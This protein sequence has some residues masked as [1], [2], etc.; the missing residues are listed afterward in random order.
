V[1]LLRDHEI[2]RVYHFAPLHYLP[3][4][5]RARALKSKPAL[6]E[7]GY[8][9]T[10]FRSTSAHIDL[11]RGFGNYVHLSTV[12]EPPILSAKLGAGFPH[13]AL[14]LDTECFEDVQFDLCRFNIAKTR[15]LRRDGKPGFCESDVNGKYYGAMQIPIAR[16]EVEKMNLL[17]SRFGN[18]MIEVLVE[19]RLPIPAGVHVKAYS[20]SDKDI[21][22][23]VLDK[24]D[25]DWLVDLAIPPTPYERDQKYGAEVEAFIAN[26]IAEPDWRGNGLEFDKV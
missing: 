16:T 5:A 26:A 1:K 9:A 4:V 2:E 6:A 20:K 17:A 19:D 18:P 3:F 8:S 21:A 25:V 12:A 10:H 7:E 23:E 13:I 24:L 15:Y 22:C 11:A 14:E